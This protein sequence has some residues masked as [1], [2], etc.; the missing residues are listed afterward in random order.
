M[1]AY[2]SLL[3]EIHGFPKGQLVHEF[4]MLLLAKRTDGSESPEEIYA[5]YKELRML[6]S[7]AIEE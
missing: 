4:S 3:S 1:H 5:K 7:A 6:F 2:S